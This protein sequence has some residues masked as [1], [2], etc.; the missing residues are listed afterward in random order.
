MMQDVEIWDSNKAIFILC[1][2]FL[3]ELFEEKSLGCAIVNHQ[4]ITEYFFYEFQFLANFI[5]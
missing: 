3:S 2:I 5:I 4:S 1:P